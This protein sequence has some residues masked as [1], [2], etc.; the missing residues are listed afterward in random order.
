M[1]YAVVGIAAAL[2]AFGVST[3]A[4]AQAVPGSAWQLAQSRMPEPDQDMEMRMPV[5]GGSNLKVRGCW[6]S[7]QIL[8]GQYRV[9]FCLDRGAD[10]YYRVEG[11]KLSCRGD[12]DWSRDGRQVDIRFNR[13]RCNRNTDWSRD[14]ISCRI[15]DAR[16]GA[17]GV[18]SVEPAQARMP[19]PGDGGEASRLNCIYRPSTGP[20]GPQRFTARRTD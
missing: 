7:R 19:V 4:S 20:Y 14:R 8:F 9:A 5:P 13:G 18:P 15:D 17:P 6:R 16:G 3:F 11:N 1:R 12:L 2:A 10:G